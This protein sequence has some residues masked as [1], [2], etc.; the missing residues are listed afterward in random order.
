MVI[1]IGTPAWYS[2]C[3]LIGFCRGSEDFVTVLAILVDT[4][5]DDKTMCEIKLRVPGRGNR[6]Y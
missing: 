4:K 2:Q 5:R 3:W 6:L 1:C